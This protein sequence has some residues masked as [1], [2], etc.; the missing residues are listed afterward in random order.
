MKPASFRMR[1]ASIAAI[2]TLLFAVALAR[3]F[4]LTVLEGG[5]LRQLAAKQHGQRLT[6][7]AERGPIVD[8][9]GDPLALTLEAASVYA[10]PR[11]LPSDQKLVQLLARTLS[12]SP[13]VIADK[14]ATSQPFV[15]LARGATLDQAHAVAQLG[16]PGLG[17]ES[18]RRRYYPRG[19]LG[20]HIIGFSN[21]DCDGI[22]GIELAYDRDL[23]GA[24]DVLTT[25][26][27]ARG[28]PI[29]TEGNWRSAPRQGARVELTIDA[30][31]QKVAE[32]ELAAAVAERRAAAGAAILMDPHTG[33]IL[34]MATEP[35]FDPNAAGTFAADRRRNRVIAD[36][37]E[38]GSTF[39]AIVAA[40]A[41]DA[42]LV[43][44]QE[45]LYCENG[46]YV[47]GAHVIHDHERYG[48]LTFAD[49]IKHSS[50]ICTAKVGERLGHKRLG[51]A[52][53]AFGFGLPTGI[54]LPGEVAGLVRPWE[55]WSRINVV[56][57]SFGQG[58]SVTPLQLVRA[59]AAI[60]N[61]G[62]LMRPYVVRR[63]LA[64]DGTV[65]RENGP[66]IVGR[67]IS[68]R[69]AATVTE[70]LRGVVED[71]TGTRAGIEGV[72]VAGKTGTAQKVD[73][74]TGRY[75]A[76]DRM[77]SF[78]GF[79]PADAPRLVMLVV[80][81]SP[82]TATYGGLVAGPVFRRIGEFAV[83]RLGLR[84][85]ARPV[86]APPAGLAP[87]LVKWTVPEGGRGMPSF[88][89]LS[90]REALVEAQ[91]AGWEVHMEGSGFVVWQDPPP[92][93][94]TAPDRTLVLRFGSPA[95]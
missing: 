64:P 84:I 7:P 83:D 82:R 75:S 36:T 4:Q 28:R 50:N 62:K 60:A 73:P 27:D 34:A 23:R 90:L 25:A 21:I 88:L 53:R 61:G 32:D 40:A 12:L 46:S 48:T 65:I 14:L 45:R 56:T 74:K 5:A 30:T 38:P 57:T 54:D 55:K 95:G 70:L 22:E 79:F 72:P 94:A 47:V 26:R 19:T 77:S 52:V 87:E 91:R 69:T 78:V 63:V 35:R 67:P 51:E 6:L 41:I 80:I 15:W 24:P 92:G 18:S 3:V 43:R 17:S 2:F 31:L 71:G 11:V 8:R 86:P 10:R 42:G 49:V 9:H 93:V 1:M 59:Y 39:K 85:A 58:I 76:R 89:G 16:M 68:A 66:E 81:D 44:P 13:A 37:Y 33:E 29:M 20:A